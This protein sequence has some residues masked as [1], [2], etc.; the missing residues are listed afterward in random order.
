MS[1]LYSGA[2]SLGQAHASI[3]LYVGIFIFII[4]IIVAI[5]FFFKKST[6]TASVVAVVTNSLCV[7]GS[8]NKQTCNNDIKYNVDGIL[9]ISKVSSPIQLPID[10]EITILYD[11]NNPYD[12][13]YNEFS[14]RII[15]LI[16]SGISIGIMILLA[17]NYYF[18]YEYKAYAAF[19]GASV[20]ANTTKNIFS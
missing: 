13:S 1:S 12:I 18:V 5:Y 2:A 6:K 14:S 16:I 7:V 10:S 4:A 9:Y 20:V 3:S 15:G 8:D 19:S 17:L 11:P